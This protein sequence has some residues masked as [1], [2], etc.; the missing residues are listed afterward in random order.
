MGTEWLET[1][2]SSGG[3]ILGG[4][5]G[6]G[7]LLLTDPLHPPSASPACARGQD[8]PSAQI[9]CSHPAGP[10]CPWATARPCPHPCP[11]SPLQWLSLTT[12][13]HLQLW[14][15]W[16]LGALSLSTT[17]RSHP[18]PSCREMAQWELAG[19][20]MPAAARGWAELKHTQLTGDRHPGELEWS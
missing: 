1:D 8:G 11:I 12:F 15:R 7:N 6:G 18:A 10:S 17:G 2:R 14:H 13:A 20:V 19:L 16:D 9:S 4:C 5:R 3:G